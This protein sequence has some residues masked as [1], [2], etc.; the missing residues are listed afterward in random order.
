M[1]APASPPSAADPKR[2]TRHRLLIAAALIG[3]AVAGLV[4]VE[5]MRERPG[6]SSPPHEPAQALI[7]P[8]PPSTPETS[9]ATTQVELADPPPPPVVVNEADRPVPSVGVPRTLP[10]AIADSASYFVQ[11]GVFTS[12]DNARSLQQRLAKA[13]I[14][15]QVETRVHLGPYKDRRE[16]E[17][18]LTKLKKIGITA[19]M[20]PAR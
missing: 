10:L 11:A 3:L 9:A 6:T 5:Q 19:V 1:T 20:V 14:R 18:A 15:S 13:G 8:P 4:A 7:A 17:Q 12:P 2:G 16:A